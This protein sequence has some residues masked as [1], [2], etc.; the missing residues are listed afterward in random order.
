FVP[1]TSFR[2]EA[3][4]IGALRGRGI[5]G[6]LRFATQLPVALGAAWRLLGAFGPQVVL[7]LG[8]YGSVPVVVAAWL[9][10]IP[11]V[12]LEQNVH[13]GWANRALARLARRVCTAFADS[14]RFFPAGKAVHT[15]NPVRQLASATRPTPDHFTVFIFGG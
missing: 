9:R 8:G 10:R 3:L 7:G 13:P 4:A 12:L 5:R 15:G 11:S 14:G 1:R 2:L 6:V